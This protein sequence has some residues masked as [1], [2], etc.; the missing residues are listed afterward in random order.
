MTLVKRFVY[1][2]VKGCADFS[3]YGDGYSDIDYTEDEASR[4]EHEPAEE[5]DE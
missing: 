4:M 2:A 5:N 1:V 3:Q